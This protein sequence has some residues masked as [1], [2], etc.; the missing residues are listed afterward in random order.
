MFE[1]ICRRKLGV[2]MALALAAAVVPVAAR[3][4]DSSGPTRIIIGFAAGGALDIVARTL[5]DKLRASL[6]TTVLVENKPGAS[7]RLALEQV[8]NS[9]PDGK[10]ILITSPSPIV[11]F[12]FTYK[13]L[14]YD[15]EK[16]L[17]P[18]A[19]IA[20]VPLVA[21]TGVS[22]PFKT[23]TE[24]VAWVKSNPASGNVGLVTLGSPTHFGLLAFGKAIGVPLTPVP[25][26]G[27]APMLTD[28]VGGSL[29]MAIDAVGGQMELLKGG[30]I[31]FLAVTGTQR[32]PL[33]PD[34]PTFKEAGIPGFDVATSWYGAFVPAGTP[35]AT[36]ARLEKAL[37]EAAKDPA[38]KEKL[39]AL[40]IETTG[41]PG[42]QFAQSIAAQRA[43]WKRVVAESG[44][45]ATD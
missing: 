35:P 16:D 6:G 10:T 44:F 23:M 1:Q 37:I 27:V 11:I 22:Q 9:A 19:H 38:V 5:A 18:V 41:Q 29:P 8:K 20:E 34:L 12:Q 36:V 39:G 15:P 4:A 3:A 33:L 42:A 7:A 30:K 26:R 14:A 25:Y 2:A 21:S 13:K 43:H 40:G 17:V 32:T 45:T 31:R 28:L 24:Y